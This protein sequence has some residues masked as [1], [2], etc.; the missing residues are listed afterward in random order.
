MPKRFIGQGRLFKNDEESIQ[1]A[2]DHIDKFQKSV[3]YGIQDIFT[4]LSDLLADLNLRKRLFFISGQPNMTAYQ[5][6]INFLQDNCSNNEETKVF[7]FGIGSD[8]DFNFLESIEVQLSN[9]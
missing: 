9:K 4:P 1:F 7:S 5:S 8:I 3:F 2:L 6:V